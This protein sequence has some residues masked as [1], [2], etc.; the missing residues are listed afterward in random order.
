[1]TID[2]EGTQAWGCSIIVDSPTGIL[3]EVQT[4]GHA[5]AQR[6]AEGYLVPVGDAVAAGPLLEFFA[7]QFNGNPPPL[8]GN[9]WTAGHLDA[10]A[11]IIGQ[12]AYWSKRPD[13]SDQ[14][15]HLQ[16]DRNRLT[17]LTEGWIPVRL[18]DGR[19]VLIFKNS[20]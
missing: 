7:K 14:R 16:L 20:D 1:M 5:T 4:G 3:Y 9:K 12:V 18:L 13:G 8:G 19:G 17:E 11:E 10:L 6:R 15:S 2:P